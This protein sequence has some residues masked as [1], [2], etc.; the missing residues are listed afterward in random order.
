MQARYFL[1]QLACLSTTLV[2]KTAER[3]D[4]IL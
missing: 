1:W 4:L 3:I 2:I